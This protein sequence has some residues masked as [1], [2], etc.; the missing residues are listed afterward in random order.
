MSDSTSLFYLTSE[1]TLEEERVSEGAR[2]GTLASGPSL[3]ETL[4][5]GGVTALGLV[6]DEGVYFIANI[7][8]ASGN[9]ATSVIYEETIGQTPSFTAGFMTV[10][11]PFTINSAG[12]TGQAGITGL[13]ADAQ[14]NQL[15]F[16]T[17]SN[18][19]VSQFGADF[20]GTPTT[21]TL[22]TLPGPA[23]AMVFDQKDSAAYFAIVT[24]NVSSFYPLTGSYAYTHEL[25]QTGQINSNYIYKVSGVTP[26][27]SGN[28]AGGTLAV[29]PLNDGKIQAE[30]LDTATDTLY[31][32]T[33]GA[34]GATSEH[35]GLYSISL[36]GDSG[37]INTIWSEAVGSGNSLTALANM[38]D[39]AI[40]PA[41]GDYY[42]STG[43]NGAQ[44]AI[45]SGNVGDIGAAPTLM[46][47]ANQVPGGDGQ[48]VPSLLDVVDGPSITGISLFAIDGNQGAQGGTIGPSDTVTIAVTFDENVS[49][50]SIP[51]FQLNN[52]GQAIY[53]S[54]AGTNVLLFTY[55]PGGGQYDTDLATATLDDLV[56]DYDGVP[57][58]NPSD[59]VALGVAVDLVPPSV[60]LTGTSL[61]AIQGGAAVKPLAGNPLI[62]DPD[63]S[64]I[65][66]GAAV[67]I[68][69]YRAGDLLMYDGETSGS[70]GSAVTWV[71]AN[72]TLTFIGRGSA[73]LFQAL[74]GGVTYQD[75]GTDE[76]TGAH[77][78]R[79]LDYS[80]TEINNGVTEISS[81]VSTTLQIDRAPEA[82]AGGYG[83]SVAA[84]AQET[85]NALT[86]DSD[87][88][89]DQLTLASVSYDGVAESPG[90][91]LVGAYGTLE[92]S[93]DGRFSY[94][95]TDISAIDA[96][97]AG[98]PPVDQFTLTVTD[99]AG[100]TT[101][102]AF[103][104]TINRPP[105]LSGGGMVT[106]HDG[107]PVG[108][109]PS[110]AIDDPDQSAGDLISGARI[111]I[112]S[113]FLAGDTLSVDTSGLPDLNVSYN[114]ATGVLDI[115]G[116][117]TAADYQ[118]AMRSL[119]FSSSAADPTDGGADTERGITYQV[120]DQAGLTSNLAAATVDVSD[121]PCF[122]AGTRIATPA[123]PV[124][125]EA[126]A[127]GDA[128]LTVRPG[129]PASRRII[130]TGKRRLTIA[131]HRQ[132]EAV[133]PIRILAGAFGP[134]RPARPLSVS[135]HHALYVDGHLFEAISL[136]NGATV[137]PDMD[138]AEIT[139]HHFELDSHDI[140]LAENLPAESFL[141]TGSRAMFEQPGPFPPHPDAA[142]PRDAAFCVPVIRSGPALHAVRQNLLDGA[143]AMG[144]TVTEEIEMA[145][146]AGGRPAARVPAAPGWFS[147]A[148]PPGLGRAVLLCPTG[149][150][151]HLHP[152]PGDLRRLGVCIG[153]LAIHDASGAAAIAL[154]DPG[155]RGFHPPEGAHRWT[156]AAA[157][158]ALPPYQGAARLDI[159]IIAA[160]ARWRGVTPRALDLAS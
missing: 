147:F 116:A 33:T 89:G 90:T 7:A 62:H 9:D 58:A 31:F 39:I 74:L 35:V 59:T 87:P 155:H 125:V 141:D 100:A 104:V 45:Y 102:E 19:D 110:L 118:A 101:T 134:G 54:G 136:V 70:L 158:I 152:E 43:P 25:Q 129:G 123:G 85:G 115:T 84:G 20:T 36:S 42:I 121:M 149:V 15:Y 146:L 112:S 46:A 113:G 109:D 160:A 34:L 18:F 107:Y 12:D 99:P 150:P 10:S 67:T 156:N 86:G 127:V 44:S 24:G 68:A 8:S 75:T 71:S 103:F 72:G 131:R 16:A 51:V 154:D 98:A 137:Y 23:Q 80:V 139:Y 151:G 77:P 38:V 48:A 79:V 78:T 126:L 148:L 26:N 73:N 130:W 66:N 95:A 106:F 69:N 91:A 40:D 47:A 114:A 17:G 2:G 1:Y 124:P 21:K 105:T 4:E 29:V 37:E 140:V 14:T 128:V 133:R 83:V 55:T 56:A 64:F 53:E 52:G 65:L 108:V 3:F 143:G 142:P 61:E 81:L 28:L 94:S 122:L 145:L 30:A 96:A 117:D 57:V 111:E 157:G 88:D 27:A 32:I 50:I 97:P 6:P 41:T 76:S 144:F 63:G 60:T 22:A 120:E 82:V 13:D 92:F 119:S 135:P 138:C 11:A 93:A 153:G 5:L 159:A 49:I 132:P